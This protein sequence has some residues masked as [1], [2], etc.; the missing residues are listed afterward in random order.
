MSL[1]DDVFMQLRLRAG[2]RE[3]ESRFRPLP[4]RNCTLAPPSVADC[5]TCQRPVMFATKNGMEDIILAWQEA[6]R[7][8][9]RNEKS[10]A[11]HLIRFGRCHAMPSS[12]NPKR[13][14][15]DFF[16]YRSEA[17]RTHHRPFSFLFF[18]FQWLDP[19]SISTLHFV[20]NDPLCIRIRGVKRGRL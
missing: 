9:E 1:N 12:L 20:F 10:A 4:H 16:G 19:K 15:K 11:I 2:W 7:L 3:G 14:G 17:T 13:G 8:V 5:G 6:T 18:F